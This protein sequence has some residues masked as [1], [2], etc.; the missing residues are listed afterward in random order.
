M[1]NQVLF[2][3]ENLADRFLERVTD[4]MIPV[5]NT[6]IEAIAKAIADT[7]RY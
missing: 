6:A 7:A 4:N 1:A 2:G 5:V 3:F